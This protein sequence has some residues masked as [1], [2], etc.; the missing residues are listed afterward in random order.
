M[1]IRKNRYFA[2][3]YQVF[4][5]EVNPRN[6]VFYLSHWGIGKGRGRLLPFRRAHAV[7]VFAQRSPVA[8][9]CEGTGKAVLASSLVRLRIRCFGFSMQREEVSFPAVSHD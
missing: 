5:A 2:H 8:Y 1:S 4:F 9:D 6:C 7:N 3:F